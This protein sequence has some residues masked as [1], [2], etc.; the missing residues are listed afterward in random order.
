MLQIFQK[1]AAHVVKVAVSE[2]VNFSGSIKVE[3]LAPSGHGFVID[4]A[5]L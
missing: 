4:Y 1:S 3:I 2:I 5:Q